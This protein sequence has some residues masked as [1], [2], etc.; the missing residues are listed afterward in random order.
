LVTVLARCLARV[1]LQ[2][3]TLRERR[4]L[5][6]LLLLHGVRHLLLHGM[7]HLLLHGVRHLLLHGMRHPARGG[8]PTR[9]AVEQPTRRGVQWRALPCHP[10]P[11]CI[12]TK[13]LIYTTHH[14]GATRVRT[15]QRDRS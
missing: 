3:I 5:L 4:L 14:A 12:P 2:G 1:L 7:R 13:Y 9:S 11:L 8:I 15:E 10:R 6:M